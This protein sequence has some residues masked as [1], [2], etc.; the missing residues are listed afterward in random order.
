MFVTH[1]DSTGAFANS[2]DITHVEPQDDDE[3]GNPVPGSYI[4]LRDDE[5]IVS[6][7]SCAE[8][9]GRLLA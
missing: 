1:N 6:P 5:T 9:L 8:I 3:H 7:L 2:D 4:Y